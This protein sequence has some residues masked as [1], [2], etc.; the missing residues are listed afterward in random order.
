ME[1]LSVN[2]YC[3]MCTKLLFLNMLLAPHYDF[4]SSMIGNFCRNM[5][6]QKINVHLQVFNISIFFPYHPA[7]NM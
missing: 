2:E 5:H 6:G 3:N 1:Y 7:L 4:S